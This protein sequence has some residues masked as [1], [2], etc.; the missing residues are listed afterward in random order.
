MDS[1]GLCMNYDPI[2]YAWA[3]LKKDQVGALA[4]LNIGK[5]LQS[6]MLTTLLCYSL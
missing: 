4:P 2:L 6:I 1:E 5:R 3:D